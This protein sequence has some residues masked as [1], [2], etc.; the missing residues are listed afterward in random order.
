MPIHPT[1]VIDPA[2]D[3]DPTAD[4]GPYAVVHGEVRIGAR[5]RVGEHCVVHPFTTLGEDNV[6]HPGVVLGGIPQSVRWDHAIPSSLEIGDRNTLREAFTAHR[7]QE[8]NG[9]TRI[10]SDNYFMVGSHIGHDAHVGNRTIFANGATIGGHAHVHDGANLSAYTLVHQYCRV[11]RLAMMQGAAAISL[12]LPPFTMAA[13]TNLLAGLNTVGMKR[14]G[15]GTDSRKAVRQAY[16]TYFLSELSVAD[17]IE[18]IRNENGQDPC[19]A[20]LLAFISASERGVLRRQRSSRAR[21][22]RLDENDG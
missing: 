3:I 7:G 17:A 4:I 12:D 6:L 9:V 8:A 13:G 2:A 21:S 18:R 14:A 10:G 22:A 20:E 11:G 15:I 16:K 5:T 19:V 1:A